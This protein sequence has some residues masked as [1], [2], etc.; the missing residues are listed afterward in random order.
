[1]PDLRSTLLLVDDSNASPHPLVELLRGAEHVVLTASDPL[2][3]LR[4]AAG[5][6][7]HGVLIHADL[8]GM[9]PLELLKRLRDFDAKRFIPAVFLMPTDDRARRIALLRDGAD[10]VV[11]APWDPEEVLVRVARCLRAT[12]RVDEALRLNAELE[13]SVFVDPLTQALNERFFQERIKEEF[14]RAQRYDAPLSLIAIDLD[15]FKAVN[16]RF[17]HPFGDQVLKEVTVFLKDTVRET[18]LVVR[19]E[20]EDFVVLLPSTH[21]SGTLTVAE[22]IWRELPLLKV[23]GAEG[24]KLTASIGVSS[25][26]HRTVLTAEQLFRTADD[27]LLRAKREG[28]NKICLFDPQSA[29]ALAARERAA[30]R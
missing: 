29:Y 6:H 26:P 13:R 19:L 20:S 27:A 10:D 15:H 30:P 17:G 1:M 28:R 18:D 9:E 24:H 7:L 12:Q 25:F 14:R 5:Q 11:C 2:D 3:A 22:R 23:K 16:D 8:P 21:L 4:V